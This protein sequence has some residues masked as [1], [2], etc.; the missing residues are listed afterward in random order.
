MKFLCLQVLEYYS[1]HRYVVPETKILL[2]YIKFLSTKL[3]LLLLFSLFFLQFI[4]LLSNFKHK[5]YGIRNT[6]YSYL[7][8]S[9]SVLI[10]SILVEK[11]LPKSRKM[12][13]TNMNM[14][15]WLQKNCQNVY[16]TIVNI[17]AKF[18]HFP[19]Y[20]TPLDVKTSIKPPVYIR[21]SHTRDWTQAFIVV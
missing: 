5:N 1:F 12:I 7:I 2:L 15:D 9:I 16:M 6:S 18:H 21:L 10:F 4:L 8:T 17:P 3:L 13:W 19:L 14:T 11:I 20:T